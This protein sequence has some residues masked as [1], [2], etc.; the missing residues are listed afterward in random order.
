VTSVTAAVRAR[1]RAGLQRA[2]QRPDL[3]RAV[4]RVRR[5]GP[6]DLRRDGLGRRGRAKSAASGISMK[7]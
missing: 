2:R 6:A 1:T 3:A 5:C 4:R 7:V